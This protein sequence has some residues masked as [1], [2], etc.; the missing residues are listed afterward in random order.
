[1]KRTNPPSNQLSREVP[2][3][4][5]PERSIPP[6]ESPAN[7]ADRSSYPVMQESSSVPTRFNLPVAEVC[8]GKSTGECQGPVVADLILQVKRGSRN[9]GRAQKFP[10]CVVHTV[11]GG[12]YS[13]LAHTGEAVLWGLV[14]SIVP[15]TPR[16][17][18]LKYRVVVREPW[19]KLLKDFRFR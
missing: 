6:K 18:H 3:G 8:I 15:R 12:V 14:R 13:W 1:M 16:G 10:L 2:E 5:C 9:V 17:L 4:T 7:R 19:R 11:R